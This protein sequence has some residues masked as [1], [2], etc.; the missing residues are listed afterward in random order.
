MFPFLRDRGVN[1]CKSTAFL[2]SMQVQKCKIIV[3][4]NLISKVYTKGINMSFN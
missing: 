2:G 4:L 3:F 1:M